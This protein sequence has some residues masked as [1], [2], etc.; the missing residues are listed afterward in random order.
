LKVKL[1]ECTG[2]GL[3]RTIW[4]RVDNLP[5]CKSC[6]GKTHTPI[7]KRPAASIKPIRNRTKKRARQEAIYARNRI[8]Y[9]NKNDAC[10]A[11]LACCK[12][13]ATDIHHKEGREGD[14]LLDESKWLSVCRNCH[15]WIENNPEEAKELDL[16]LSR[17]AKTA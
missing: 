16:S 2:C 9:L 12:Y 10:R 15:D 7:S 5:Y 17:L 1:K 11:Q 6:Y 3:P 13:V 14:L 8:K 4:K